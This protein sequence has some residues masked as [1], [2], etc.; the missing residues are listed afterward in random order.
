MK[1]RKLLT[2]LVAGL[3][4]LSGCGNTA[5][6]KTPTNTEINK[7]ELIANINK[8]GKDQ[9]SAEIKMKNSISLTESGKKKDVSIEMDIKVVVDPIQ[10]HLVLNA[11]SSN[12]EGGL[13][14][15]SYVK[16]GFTYTNTPIIEQLKDVW[17][18]TEYDQEQFKSIVEQANNED[19]TKFF[20]NV[21]KDLVIKEVDNQ[22]EIKYEK[23]N[24]S[25]KDVSLIFTSSAFSGDTLNQKALENT[26]VDKIL[27]TYYV[28][29]T[30]YQAKS[31]DMQLNL[32][33]K[34]NKESKMEIKTEATYSGFNSINEIKVPEEIL[35][36]AIS[37]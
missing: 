22:Y 2:S 25:F 18:K 34:E 23:E 33:Q 35:T 16:D 8:A 9:K 30:T 13:T 10:A 32:S 7:T 20:T 28:D 14:M 12:E 29:K 1:F 15:T 31:M 11:K 21:E 17:V 3:L 27:L 26:N 5:T 24:I 6:S 37:Q 19:Y 4:V 36:K